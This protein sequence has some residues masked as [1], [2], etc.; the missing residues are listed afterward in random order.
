[1]YEELPRPT[2]FAH[3]GA[4]AYAP[5]NTLAAFELA[6]RQ[7]AD[8]IELD[9]KLSSDGYIVVIH[10]KSVDRTTD[11]SGRVA[12]LPLAALKEL[13]AGCKYD[14]AYCEERIPTLEEVFVRLGH[15][16]FINIELSNYEAPFNR[17]PEKV[18]NVI[19][20]H[21]FENRVIISSFNP[22]ALRRIH[23]LL[24]DT[25]IGLLALP[26]ISGV[27]ARSRLNSWV[28]HQALHPAF[29]S[30]TKDLIARQQQRG[31]RVHVYTVNHPKQILRLVRWGVDGIFT[32]DPPMA[33][34]SI[35]RDAHLEV[36]TA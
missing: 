35:K 12:D 18:A 34:R 10:D 19:K 2:I 15:E 26:G 11:G 31:I 7:G 21:G 5:E 30:T 6:I 32:D 36:V 20:R 8:A 22:V 13:D 14:K 4:C 33:R 9:A 3:R 17:L 24:P 27:W 25:P 29:Q 16:T 1:M 28:P 23:K